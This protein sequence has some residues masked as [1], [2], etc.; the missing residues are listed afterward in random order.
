M[1]NLLNAYN[2]SPA[3]IDVIHIS[4]GAQPCVSKGRFVRL[5]PVIVPA[6]RQDV[7]SRS[8]PFSLRH[9]SLVFVR[10]IP[11]STSTSRTTHS[12]RSSPM[13]ADRSSGSIYS[14]HPTSPGMCLIVRRTDTVPDG[15]HTACQC[16]TG[17]CRDGS[18]RSIHLCYSDL[19]D[20]G[21]FKFS[22]LG[23]ECDTGVEEGFARADVGFHRLVS[24][25]TKLDL[26]GKR[27]RDSV[28]G[29]EN[30]LVQQKLSVGRSV[31][32]SVCRRGDQAVYS[33]SEHVAQSVIL[34]VQEHSNRSFQLGVILNLHAKPIQDILI[35]SYTDITL[36]CRIRTP[37]GHS[38][39]PRAMLRSYQGDSC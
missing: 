2:H 19:F 5:F 7:P 9:A 17:T 18:G 39:Y 20:E 6:H 35:R 16:W 31:L 3:Q 23:H 13:R 28:A 29:E 1:F 38:R 10:I 33:R 15:A 36:R 30:V 32:R 12:R 21:R 14:A 34:R 25:D 4:Q 26:V 27:M 37:L 8:I 24:L 11:S 22:G